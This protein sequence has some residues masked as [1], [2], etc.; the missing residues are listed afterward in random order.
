VIL[1]GQGLT[2]LVVV[3]GGTVS[4]IGLTLAN[5]AVRGNA[6]GVAHNGDWGA[7]GADGYTDGNYNGTKGGNGK[8]GNPGDPGGNGGDA[9]GGAIAVLSGNAQIAGVTIK[10]SVAFGGNGA[11]G[12]RGGGG[13]VGG[14]GGNGGLGPVVAYQ[15]PYVGP[16]GNGGP[17]GPGAP[18][19]GGGAGGQALGGAI[20]NA[21]TLTV[22]DS[23]FTNNQARG[24]AGGL[25]G[26]G[27]AGGQ[28]GTG[29]LGRGFQGDNPASAAGNGAD[30]GSGGA[31]GLGGLAGDGRGGAIYNATGAHLT[32]QRTTF[33]ANIAGGG[34]GG[35][36]QPGGNGGTGGNGLGNQ[37]LNNGGQ[38][39]S[40]GNGGN[41][42]N[43]GSA[44][45]SGNSCGGALN[46]ALASATT[47]NLTMANNQ[48][49]AGAAGVP[50]GASIG[51]S[52]GY[53]TYYTYDPHGPLSG[54]PGH[55][56]TNGT[57]GSAASVGTAV[58]PDVCGSTNS[59]DPMIAGFGF[60]G[61]DS[62]SMVKPVVWDQASPI[63]PN[64]A[65]VAT[66]GAEVDTWELGTNFPAHGQSLDYRRRCPAW[67][68]GQVWRSCSGPT[69]EPE[70]TG[71]ST[72]A[73]PVVAG[74]QAKLKLIV[75]QAWVPAGMA[76][77]SEYLAGDVTINGALT[78]A[79]LLTSTTKFTA[80]PIGKG[81][82]VDVGPVDFKDQGAALTETAGVVKLRI[83]WCFESA[84]A[85]CSETGKG[86]ISVGRSDSLVYVIPH[87]Q[88]ATPTATWHAPIT[89]KPYLTMVD[90][91]VTGVQFNDDITTFN[92]MYRKFGL[93]L[94]GLNSITRTILDPQSGDV[95]Q[96][97][98][99]GLQYYP[100]AWTF[101]KQVT[102]AYRIPAA[103]RT[104][105][106]GACLLQ[107]GLDACTEW[108]DFL[109]E[110][111][112]IDGIK[113]KSFPLGSGGSAGLKRD[114]WAMLIG[115]NKWN[116]GQLRAGQ[117]DA[118]QYN[119]AAPTVA[120]KNQS[121]EFTYSGVVGQGP[122]Q[123]T[124]GWFRAGDHVIVS[125][126]GA[127]Y[128]PSYGTGPFTASGS[129]KAVGCWA[130]AN[131]A[132]LA[133]VI[134]GSLPKGDAWLPP[135]CPQKPP[136]GLGLTMQYECAW[137]VFDAAPWKNWNYAP[138]TP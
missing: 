50:G 69:G 77:S 111:A 76:L 62:A 29:G 2:Q 25:G 122:N 93:G 11:A 133:S 131:V 8:P 70:A 44:G 39:G 113:A 99:L 48:V 89:V 74:H 55:A 103:C 85:P 86:Q 83:D 57:A 136:A 22:I 114:D 18:G 66:V 38:L 104:G 109:T 127:V 46:V 115:P 13:G 101:K 27:G 130:Q 110:V 94:L 64:A 95:S 102:G 34:D 135:V 105:D 88:F 12:G 17:G 67:K 106:L 65:P 107:S 68:T 75:A 79:A 28:G 9:Q 71:K 20:Y 3:S 129:C 35:G 43:G 53:Y 138:P 97:E 90:L 16:G 56:G 119:A 59:A 4:L 54:K 96:H 134:S 36:S 30:A 26:A 132:G 72:L 84:P 118:Y 121:N 49:Q 91:A 60:A 108:A 7:D 123:S 1:D 63:N 61:T 124:P 14:H 10:N 23:Q 42:A 15:N 126:N 47:Q 87:A 31:A 5:G 78:P 98:G 137:K 58:S 81:Q 19:G 116:N 82:L 6:P 117:I 24:G 45:S 92:S 80:S 125:F 100:A 33:T 32:V 73:W 112:A 40:A 37:G 21:G 52:P 41:G 120:F 51:G 128:D